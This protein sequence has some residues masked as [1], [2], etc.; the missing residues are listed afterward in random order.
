V[1]RIRS[2]PS[3]SFCINLPLGFSLNVGTAVRK[4]AIWP[5]TLTPQHWVKFL[6][7]NLGKFYMPTYLVPFFFSH[8]MKIAKCSHFRPSLVSVRLVVIHFNLSCFQAL[9]HVI[10]REGNEEITSVES[11]LCIEIDSQSLKTV[12]LSQKNRKY[13]HKANIWLQYSKNECCVEYNHCIVQLI[14]KS[15]W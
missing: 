14:S 3:S 8:G 11:S 7:E 4:S 5:L 10:T 9:Y 15:K 1:V 2:V 12:W 6:L 13:V